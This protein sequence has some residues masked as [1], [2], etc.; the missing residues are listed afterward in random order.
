MFGLWK[1]KEE[2]KEEKVVKTTT[3]PKKKVAKKTIKKKPVVKKKTQ[4]KAKVVVKT[5]NEI[6]IDK[7]S[8]S[9]QPTYTKQEI[10]NLLNNK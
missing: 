10:I 4:K 7:I 6:L 5:G 8:N 9:V 1:K 3:K 2:V